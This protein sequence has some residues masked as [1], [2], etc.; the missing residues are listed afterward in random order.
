MCSWNVSNL[1]I[2]FMLNFQCL[3]RDPRDIALVRLVILSLV[4]YQD[5]CNLNVVMSCLLELHY[6]RLVIL[7]SDGM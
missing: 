5:L 4:E 7:H 3:A 2:P 1:E 6:G